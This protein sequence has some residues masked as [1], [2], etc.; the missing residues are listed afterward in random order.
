MKQ[1]ILISLMLVFMAHASFSQFTVTGEIRPRGEVRNGFKM[2]PTETT[3]PAFF[4]SQRT[5]LGLAYK[6]EKISTKVTFQDARVWGDEPYKTDVPNITLYE[7]WAEIP[8]CDSLSLRVGKQELAFDN[9]R[10]LSANSWTQLGASHNAALLKYNKSGLQIDFAA[11][12]NQAAENTFGTDYTGLTSSYKSLNILWITKKIGDNLKVSVAG[13]ADGYQKIGS[14]NTTYLRGTFGGIVE[15]KKEKQFG[16]AVRG[17][18]QMGKLSN[19][20][21]VAAYYGSA[22]VSHTLADKWTLILGLEYISGNDA[23]DTANR[24][25]NAFSV[26][27]GA[28]HKFNGNMEYFSTM[29]KD[30][31]SPGLIDPYINAI[32]K[33]NDKWQIRGDFH[34]FILQN[35]YVINTDPIDKK[36]GAEADITCKYNFAKE[37]ALS[38]GFSIMRPN[39][40]MEPIVGGDSSFYGTWGFVMLTFKPTMFKSE[41]K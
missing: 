17:F 22:E 39:K 32:Y 19:G 16:A 21:E 1:R 36:L 8:L 30:K 6:A 25:S 28:G 23:T 4:V 24:K 27:Y 33:V 12:F 11:A 3:T 26:L 41:K 20:Q 31:K 10:L 18:Y 7:A 38:L 35:N 14:T 37:A 15:Y 34:Y 2:L 5:R 29:L 9:D 40:S 13:I